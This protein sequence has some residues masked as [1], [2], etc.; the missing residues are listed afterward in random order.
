M[1]LDDALPA[2]EPWPHLSDVDQLIQLHD[3]LAPLR[4]EQ[5][6]WLLAKGMPPQSLV[7]PDPLRRADV[8]FMP[9]GRF[10]FEPD[11]RGDQA[12][13]EAVLILAY[14]PDG[15]PA[16]LVAW[17][18][19]GNRLASWQGRCPWLGYPFGPRCSERLA[20]AVH[21]GVLPWLRA[22]RSGVVLIEGAPG[23]AR[24]LDGAGPLIAMG[25]PRHALRLEGLLTPTKPRILIANPDMR[26]AS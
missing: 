21:E 5:T 3:R 20:L 7:A 15:C 18:P 22:G 8:V 14:E 9:A 10:E 17:D 13:T 26:I 12:A 6:K 4:V 24:M 16:D 19:R 23:L 11:Y 25:G 2:G 1:T